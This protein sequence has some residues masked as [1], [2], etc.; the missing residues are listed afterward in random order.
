M[1]H[2]YCGENYVAF[3][4]KQNKYR[5]IILRW[6]FMPINSIVHPTAAGGND[7]ICPS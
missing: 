2:S 6:W 3:I 7:G 4:S 1:D 5:V